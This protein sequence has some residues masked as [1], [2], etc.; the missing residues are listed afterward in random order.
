MEDNIE[1]KDSEH[2]A[3][4]THGIHNGHDHEQSKCCGRDHKKRYLIT[5]IILIIALVIL[6]VYFSGNFSNISTKDAGN[7]TV[8]FLNARV[9]GGVE[10]KSV[11]D[12]G[13]LYEIIVT[14]N[15]KDIPVYAT[16]DGKY[17]IQS[18][19]PIIGEDVPHNKVLNQ[20]E[21][22]Q[23]KELI[24]SD[25]PKIELFVMTH[26]PFGTQAEKGIM[27]AIK[28]LGSKIDF[29][30]KFVH[31]FMH[32]DKEEKETYN[33]VCIREEQK[34]KYTAYLECFLEDGN[35]ERC[36]TKAGI[37]IDKLNI[38]L[39][40]KARDYYAKDSDLS[41][42][43]QI[44]GSPT[45]IINGVETDSARSPSAFLST[46]CSAFS[47]KPEECSNALSSENPSSGF[48]YS[49]GNSAATAQCGD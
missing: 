16:K 9:G 7:L 45:L 2:K 40:K 46:I 24:K 14:Y 47:N 37:N 23:P 43:Y 41:N 27:P 39:S 30:I 11:K 15:E 33:Q 38:C 12:I 6:F 21:Q 26:C 49:I 29:S 36:I 31:Y 20:E 28:T 42:K 48:G 5:S 4:E 1:N 34:D 32:G 35:S 19:T 8:N 10:Y 18:I 25:K 22:K 13:N 44:Q 17:F 3:Q